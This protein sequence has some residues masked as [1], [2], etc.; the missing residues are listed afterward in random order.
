MK[1]KTKLGLGVLEAA[2]LLGLLGDALLRATPWGLNIFLW[3]GALT[4][5]M[6][7]LARL[8]KTTS[9][10]DGERWLLLCVLLFAS[11][12]AWRDSPTLMLLDGAAILVALSLAAAST[13]D[14]RMR[15]A[16]LADTARGVIESAGNTVF[17]VFP[18]LLSD[19][20]WK[21]IP[22]AKWSRYVMPVVRGLV[23]AVPLLVV[24]GA[25]LMAADAIFEDIVQSTFRVNG[26]EAL[27]HAVIVVLCAWLS[28]G[29]LRGMLLGGGLQAASESATPFAA[30]NPGDGHARQSVDAAG[31]TDTDNG[32]PHN[33][34][35]HHEAVADK[36]G[37]KRFADGSSVTDEVNGGLIGAA[38]VSAVGDDAQTSSAGQSVN[39]PPEATR[40]K[41][42][43]L[44]IIEVS[45]VLGLMNLLFLCFV[46]VQ[47]RY[48]F[49][50][51][52]L[53]LNSPGMTYAEYAR[54]GFFELVTV[55]ALVLPLLLLAHWF[56]RRDNP[57][58]ERVFHLLAGAQIALLFVI[59]ASAFARMRLY[60]SEYGMTELRLYTT[61]FMGWLAAV[62]A[63]F[64][65]TVLR[66]RRE[67]F[68]C[69][70]LVAAF[71]VTGLL[72]LLNPDAFIVRANAAL[73]GTGRG[74]DAGYAASL[75]ADAVPA[76][77]GAIPR[78]SPHDRG[79]IAEA[80][81]SRWDST[82]N[83][84]WRTWNWS[85]AEAAQ[86]ARKNEALLI[87][88]SRAWKQEP[89]AGTVVPPNA[90]REAKY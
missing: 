11:A 90:A 19:I 71:V 70:A 9:P 58:H 5:A 49:G 22:R 20:G 18:L 34:A 79:V 7:A 26:E 60:Q 59:M 25:L 40:R 78:L 53:I 41:P 62:F 10:P 88:L 52:S 37:P 75:S 76:L 46:A 66:G 74:F 15:L 67:H 31:R 72:H 56:L 87:E 82:G 85:R 27:T 14:N 33:N 32:G 23:I 6:V 89:G 36:D 81:L 2:L 12:F 30:T 54:R 28:G 17:G 44:G 77:V 4:A 80:L 84:D 39:N 68:A 63:W 64:G 42:W 16:G 73:A 69:G 45:T 35:V 55:A 83:H 48:L 65:V 21:E 38:P 43:S 61:A 51:A 24:F 86:T 1:E 47:V 29:F 8:K 57:A 50:G 13:R 3:V